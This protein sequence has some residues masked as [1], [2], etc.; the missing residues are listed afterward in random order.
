M[1]NIVVGAASGLGAAAARELAP[2]GRLLLADRDIGGVTRLAT[3]LGGKAEAVACDL[4][5]R[6]QIDA[7]VG[8]IGG[9]IEAL[10]ITARCRARWRRDASSSTS[11]SLPWNICCTL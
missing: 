2:R 6:T 11:I 8:R 1:T 5:D 4:A 10:V 3:E 9:D 7:L